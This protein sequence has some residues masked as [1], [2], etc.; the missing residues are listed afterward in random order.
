MHLSFKLKPSKL[1]SYSGIANDDEANKT[2]RFDPRLNSITKEDRSSPVLILQNE[3]ASVRLS[4]DS[5]AN[6]PRLKITDLREGGTTKYFD[7]ILIEALTRI[8]KNIIHPYIT[9]LMGV[10][11]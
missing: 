3:F 11:D 4:L 7:P 2:F 5:T 1:M 8:P 9:E 6:G 10:T